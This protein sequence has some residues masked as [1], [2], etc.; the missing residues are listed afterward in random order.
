[1]NVDIRAACLRIIRLLLFEN[2][3]FVQDFRK[4]PEDRSSCRISRCG[5]VRLAVNMVS[6]IERLCL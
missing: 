4:C 2:S 6:S 1:M 5:K 3:E